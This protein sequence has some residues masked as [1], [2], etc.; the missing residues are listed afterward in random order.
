MR[1][2]EIASRGRSLGL[3]ELALPLDLEALLP[4]DA[5]WELEVGFGKGRYLLGRAV[6]APPVRLLGIEVAGRYF[7]MVRRRAERRGLD[8]VLVHGEALYVMSTVLPAARFRAVHVYFPDPWPKGRHHKR[9]LFERD[10][11]DILLTRLEPGGRISF[12]TDHLDYGDRVAALLESHPALGVERPVGWPDGAR[13]HYE[14]KYERQGR[15][16]L[17]LEA[18]LE[19]DVPLVHPAGLGDLVAGVRPGARV[20]EPVGALSG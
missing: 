2:L 4:G 7:R 14:L 5:P 11:I 3:A 12:A 13:T 18:T 8:V 6:E 10:T 9:R 1:G 16:I 20:A 19:P 15:P 17:R